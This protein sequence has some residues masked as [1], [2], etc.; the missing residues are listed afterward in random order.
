MPVDRASIRGGSGTSAGSRSERGGLVRQRCAGDGADGLCRHQGLRSLRARAVRQGRGLLRAHALVELE[1]EW[2]VGRLHATARRHG[3]DGVDRVCQGGE[4]AGAPDGGTPRG[5]RCS[6]RTRRTGQ[7]AAACECD[8][9]TAQVRDKAQAASAAGEARVHRVRV[10]AGDG[11]VALARNAAGEIARGGS[12]RSASGDGNR[13][14]AAHRR[15]TGYRTAAAATATRG[16]SAGAR[17]SRADGPRRYH[18]APGPH[19]AG[20]RHPRRRLAAQ[21]GASSRA[22][23]GCGHHR[24]PRDPERVQPDRH[25]RRRRARAARV[26]ADEGNVA[27][28]G[29]GVL[30]SME[31]CV[32]AP[33]EPGRHR[34]SWRCEAARRAPLKGHALAAGGGGGRADELGGAPAQQARHR[35]RQRRRAALGAALAG[36]RRGRAGGGRIDEPRLEQRREPACDR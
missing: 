23:P 31:S 24:Q 16:R 1:G 36:R 4:G 27:R 33:I 6:P 5:G 30:C 32:P 17:G 19:H 26:A 7:G 9:Y 18:R 11:A 20:R 25:H 22:G 3:L 12:A 13:G 21:D 14:G 10:V 34:S 2:C 35:Q 15:C 8:D 28:Q 29:A